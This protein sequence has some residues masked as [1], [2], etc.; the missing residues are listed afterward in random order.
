MNNKL[1]LIKI[2]TLVVFY[3]SFIVN[4]FIKPFKIIFPGK[5]IKYASL[6]DS[7]LNS[8]F[9]GIKVFFIIIFIISIT[10]FVMLIA[11]LIG[12][13]VKKQEVKNNKIL[14]FLGYELEDKDIKYF[15]YL[16]SGI[17]VVILCLNGVTYKGGTLLEIKFSSF[18]L[19]FL[20]MAIMSIVT[21]IITHLTNKEENNDL[22]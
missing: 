5:I 2:I 3:L 11:C 17:V 14:R 15:A 4:L 7:N 18:T 21:L 12:N 9:S 13:C 16:L 10:V 1:K 19:S 6:F 20:I 22:F 8:Y